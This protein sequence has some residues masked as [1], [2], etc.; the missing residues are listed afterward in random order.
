MGKWNWW[1]PGWLD[2]RLPNADFES[3]ATVETTEERTPATV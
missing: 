3:D 2:R 1:L